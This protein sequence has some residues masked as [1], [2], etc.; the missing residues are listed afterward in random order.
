MEST[1]LSPQWLS[2]LSTAKRCTPH[3]PRHAAHL[4]ACP[5]A[6]PPQ[7]SLSRSSPS[8]HVNDRGGRV[9]YLAHQTCQYHVGHPAHK[10]TWS[11]TAYLVR[12]RIRYASQQWQAAV[13]DLTAAIDLQPNFGQGVTGKERRRKGCIAV[14]NYEDSQA[15]ANRLVK[16][17]G[18]PSRVHVQKPPV[19]THDCQSS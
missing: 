19:K 12:G 1:A 2:R 8:F 13:K 3:G 17:G 5:M 10:L 18:A 7:L 4:Y 9:V 15:E 6:T 14:P 11:L 16:V